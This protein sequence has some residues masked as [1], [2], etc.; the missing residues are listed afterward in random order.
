MLQDGKL[1]CGSPSG[2]WTLSSMPDSNAEDQ[3][4]LT[5]SYFIL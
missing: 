1:G 4:S 3:N 2:I 5:I